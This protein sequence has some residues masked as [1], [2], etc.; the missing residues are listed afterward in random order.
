MPLASLPTVSPGARPSVVLSPAS[1]RNCIT[2]VTLLQQMGTRDC[3]PWCH[4]RL[5]ALYSECKKVLARVGGASLTGG[6]HRCVP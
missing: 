2:V 6:R 1:S 5:L 4:Q 3:G